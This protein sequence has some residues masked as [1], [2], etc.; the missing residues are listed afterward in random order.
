MSRHAGREQ[1]TQAPDEELRPS[2]TEERRLRKD[3][4]D[5]LAKLSTELCALSDRRLTGLGLP[6]TVER[7]VLEARRIPSPTARNRALRRVRQELRSCDSSVIV[8]QLRSDGAPRREPAARKSEAVEAWRTRLVQEG[9]GGIDALVAD[10]PDAE[11][12]ALRVLVRNLKQATPTTESRAR[13]ALDR[14]LETLLK[15]K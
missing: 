15:R 5:A 2:R 9:D 1:E 4:E 6:E 14:R 11:R 12:K 7:A 10:Y 13:L 8:A 3:A